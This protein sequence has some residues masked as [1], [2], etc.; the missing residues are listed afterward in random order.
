MMMMLMILLSSWC[1]KVAAKAHDGT[2]LSSFC[3]WSWKGAAIDKQAKR[4]VPVMQGLLNSPV[5]CVFQFRC[6]WRGFMY[7][8]E[9]RVIK[10]K[11][12]MLTRLRDRLEER[13][14]HW[15]KKV[16]YRVFR[17]S[18]FFVT[19]TCSEL[20]SISFTSIVVLKKSQLRGPRLRGKDNCN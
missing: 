13:E 4:S 1:V 14:V 10:R 9:Q 19:L 5:Q 17:F 6:T 3:C 2:D 7:R 16:L 8:L 15:R 20:R 18:P 12:P 11:L